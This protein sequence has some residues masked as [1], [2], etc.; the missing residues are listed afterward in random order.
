[1]LLEIEKAKADKS[2]IEDEI[3]ELMEKIDIESAVIKQAEADFKVFE[4][5]TNAEIEG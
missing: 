4:Q 1:M 2:V 5:K 3:L